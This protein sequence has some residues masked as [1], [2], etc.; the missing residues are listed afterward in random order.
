MEKWIAILTCG[1]A[2]FFTALISHLYAGEHGRILVASMGASAVILFILPSSPLAQPWSFA[3]GQML[4]AIAGVYCSYFILEPALAAGL[5]VA[6]AVTAMLCLRCLHPP[7]AATALAP[8]L[9]NPHP[10]LLDL[11]FLL[12]PM[13]AN[14]CLMLALALLINKILLRRNYP[15]IGQATFKPSHPN[16]LAQSN[17]LNIDMADIQQALAQMDHVLDISQHDLQQL[18]TFL[19]VR[20]VEKNSGLQTCADIMQLGIV[21]V[22]YA[23]EVETAWRMLQEQH[24]TVMPVLDKARRVIGI[25]T[26]HDFLKQLKLTPFESFQEK[27]LKFIRRTHLIHTKKPESI[28]HIMSRRVKTL[29][30]SANIAELIP[31]IVDQ[32]HRHVP[33]VDAEG[34]F[35]GIVFQSRLIAAL[36]NHQLQASMPNPTLQ[37]A[38]QNI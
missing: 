8:V 17:L 27:W 14:V 2:I 15:A 1:A 32:G 31:L 11:D 23:T 7:G 3:G 38:A 10:P 12:L 13:A 9:S 28:G 26:R 6:L 4:S 37:M 34:R 20:S 16:P 21:T 24:L 5:S 36:F 19:H 30:A 35:V 33:L 29:P 22:E 18:L 25:V